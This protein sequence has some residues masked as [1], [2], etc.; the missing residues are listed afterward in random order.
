MRRNWTLQGTCTVS[1]SDT[2]TVPNS[3]CS[4][5]GASST[6][7]AAGGASVAVAAFR[8]RAGDGELDAGAPRLPFPLPLG[9]AGKAA[10]C[11]SV[12]AGRASSMAGTSSCNWHVYHF[13]SI[14]LLCKPRPTSRR[15]RTKLQLARPALLWQA[16]VNGSTQVHGATGGSECGDVCRRACNQHFAMDG[17]SSAP[18]SAAD[19][20]A[21]LSCSGPA[22]PA[23]A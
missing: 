2:Q 18:A 9:F 10:G 5:E 7:A 8:L 15:S 22:P 16:A 6:A 3:P 4:E 11:S 20:S 17:T 23:A 21:L 12:V 13:E 1:D 19:G 14:V